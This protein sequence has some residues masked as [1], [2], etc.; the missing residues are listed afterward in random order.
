MWFIT[1]LFSGLLST[2]NF[3]LRKLHY[4]GQNLE[5]ARFHRHKEPGLGFRA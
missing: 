3:Q 1:T 4:R 5:V 2:L